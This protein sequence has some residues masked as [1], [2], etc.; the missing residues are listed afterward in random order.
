V[1][2]FSGQTPRR[3]EK[4]L[5]IKSSELK[6]G[7]SGIGKPPNNGVECGTSNRDF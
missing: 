2:L 1:I 7:E 6:S 3:G 5:K 4:E